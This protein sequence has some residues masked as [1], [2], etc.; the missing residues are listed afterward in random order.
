MEKQ[1]GTILSHILSFHFIYFY[2]HTRSK[3]NCAIKRTSYFYQTLVTR[4][5]KKLCDRANFPLTAKIKIERNFTLDANIVTRRRIV[6]RRFTI[7]NV[8]ID[9]EPL[10]SGGTADG[11]DGD[12][13]SDS[14][15]P[16]SDTQQAAQAEPSLLNI[17][18]RDK[19]FLKR[20]QSTKN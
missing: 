20:R 14:A 10:D 3:N 15:T 5:K 6:E 1:I 9:D 7:G 8:E 19:T 2:I 12:N 13:V 18:R 16:V 11:A 17:N 4:N